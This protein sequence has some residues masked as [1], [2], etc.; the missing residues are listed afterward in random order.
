MDNTVCQS[1]FFQP[2]L[3][4]LESP[5][6][7]PSVARLAVVAERMR[8]VGCLGHFTASP[9]ADISRRARRSRFDARDSVCQSMLKSAL[10]ALRI[11]RAILLVWSFLRPHFDF[12]D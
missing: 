7:V 10:E 9:F 4:R 8:L 11:R 2:H 5:V 6:P 3:F 1:S 12:F